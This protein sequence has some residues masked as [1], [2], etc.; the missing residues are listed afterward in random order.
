MTEYDLFVECLP[1]IEEMVIRCCRL[2]GAEYEGWKRETMK[3]APETV[4]IFL[5]KVLILIDSV[6]LS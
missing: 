5:S 6:V 4:K 1:M 3:H 2:S